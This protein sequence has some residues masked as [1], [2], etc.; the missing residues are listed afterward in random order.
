METVK[1]FLPDD[2]LL[3]NAFSMVQDFLGGITH[4][5]LAVDP[6]SSSFMDDYC[7]GMI[8]GLN[9]SNILMKIATTLRS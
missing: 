5:M 1:P 9:G 8:F 6:S 3:E 7:R 2:L 4:L